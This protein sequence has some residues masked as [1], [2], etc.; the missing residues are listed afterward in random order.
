MTR[1]ASSGSRSRTK[2]LSR[3]ENSARDI[4]ALLD[5][6]Q[7]GF[8]QEPEAP[9]VRDEMS[10]AGQIKMPACHKQALLGD[11]VENLETVLGGEGFADV[12]LARD[13]GP[14]NLDLRNMH[15]VSPHH[16]RLARGIETISAVSGGVARQRQ[17]C[18]TRK[19]AS[20]A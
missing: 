3:A 14:R 8:R 17:L 9:S 7:P 13:L 18:Q 5:L 1:P 20:S 4:R 19:H 12:K 2:V 11:V 15:C 10:K 6:D 16:E